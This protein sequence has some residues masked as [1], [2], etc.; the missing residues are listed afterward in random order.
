MTISV[1]QS[2]AIPAGWSGNMGQAA[3]AGNTLFLIPLGFGNNGSPMS[4]SGPEYNGASVSGTLKLAEEQCT[5]VDKTYGAIYMLPNLPSSSEA[6]AITMNNSLA[7]NN[8]GL[9]YIEVSGLGASPSADPGSP[10][11]ATSG[12]TPTTAISCGP[13]P[14]LS[15]APEIVIA[16]A[17][18]DQSGTSLSSGG[19]T[20]F[21]VD[22]LSN[23]WVGYQVATS[24]GG[25]Y[26]WSQTSGPDSNWMAAIAS[27][28]GTPSGTSHTATASLTVTPTF[29]ASRTRGRYRTGSLTVTPSFTAARTRGKYRT[30]L[31]TVSPSFSATPVL[32][33]PGTD[34]GSGADSDTLTASLSGTDTGA[35]ADTA[36]SIGVTPADTGTGT[37]AASATAATSSADTGSGADAAAIAASVPGSDTG[38]GSDAGIAAEPVSDSDTGAGTDSGSAAVTTSVPQL[39]AGLLGG[40]AANANLYAG[41]AS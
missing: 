37:E 11:V 23:A 21:S 36:V 16:C 8:V 41:S 18:N 39:R 5:S 3:A 26:S 9:G 27:V 24:S 34:A 40:T 10:T 28:Y 22:G 1:V 6:I 19:W 2:G 29:S 20:G 32:G 38:T 31:L 4:T 30:G 35:G 13:T 7:I 15:D 14:A 25:T 33:I 17:G 12:S